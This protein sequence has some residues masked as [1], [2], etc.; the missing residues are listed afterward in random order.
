MLRQRA[1]QMHDVDEF[2]IGARIR[3]SPLGKRR[4]PKMTRRTGIVVATGVYR[5]S[6][7]VLMDGNKDAITL[8]RSY[9]D[10]DSPGVP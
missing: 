7:R 5:Q 4:C 1:V 8:H 2:E 3:L 10:A 9:I 6:V